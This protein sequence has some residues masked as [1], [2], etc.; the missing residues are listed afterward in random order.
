M[1]G[2]FSVPFVIA[3]VIA[4]TKYQQAIYGGLALVALTFATFRVWKAEYET[5]LD[6]REKIRRAN[7]PLPDMAIHDLF[8]HIDPEFLTRADE[9]VGDRWDAV[10]NLI[11]DR[12]ALGGLKIWG[13]P[14][15]DVWIGCWVR[16]IHCG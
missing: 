11:R 3:M 5:T 1:S 4:D 2:A 7:A 8:S 12:A 15:R 16:L 9:S 10:G 13:R 14:V 6:L